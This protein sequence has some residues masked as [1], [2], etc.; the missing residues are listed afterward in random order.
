[1]IHWD[2]MH[3]LCASGGVAQHGLNEVLRALQEDGI[4]LREI[5][6]FHRGALWTLNEKHLGQSFFVERWNRDTYGHLKCFA[7]ET[8]LACKVLFLFMYE[9]GGARRWPDL[10]RVVQ[11]L[12]II[13]T[14][15]Q[16]GDAAWEKADDM[17]RYLQ[18]LHVL[19]LEVWGADMIRPKNHFLYMSWTTCV[20]FVCARAHFR[21]RGGTRYSS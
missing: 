18:E 19:Y 17:G 14:I 20:G 12:D 6:E 9:K 15:F 11:I 3:C 13:I 7:S 4:S 21:M 8:I 2:W 10:F 1:M 5:D 16:K